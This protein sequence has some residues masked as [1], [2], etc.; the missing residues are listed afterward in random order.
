MSST[1]KPLTG[2]V[3]ALPAR[4]LSEETC[5]K[6]GYAVS[7]LA[8]GT[9]VQVASYYVKGTLV[10]QHTRDKNKDFKWLGESKGVELFGQ[11]LWREGGKMVVVT[12]G[13]IDAMSI[14]Q[15]NSHKYPV[16]SLPSGINGAVKALK[17]NLEWLETFES[18]ILMFDND[19]Q[20]TQAAEAVSK[21]VQECAALFTPGRCKIAKLP[22]KDANEML[23]ANR[24]GEVIEAIFGARE[25]RPDGVVSIADL[26][27]SLNKPVEMGLSWPWPTLTEYTYGI[28]LDEIYTL[29]AGTGMGK[30][31]F[32]KEVMVHLAN[33]H[34][35]KVGGL[36]LEETPAHTVRCLAGK[37]KDKRFH[38]PN[39]GWVQEDLDVAV[40]E[41]VEMDKIFL[42]DHFGHTDYEVIKARIRFMA[43]S[44]GC[45]YIFIDHITAL[46][47]G[48]L[49]GDE[50]KQLDYIMTD[51]A[52]LCRELHIAIF[53][54]SHLTSPEG[55]PHE[56]GGRVLL[57]QF[58]GSRAIG[59][60][61]SFCI[62][63]E[64]NQ[65]EQDEKRRNIT[66]V[67]VLKDRYT[68]EATGKLLYLRYEAETG[69]MKETEGPKEERPFS[70]KTQRVTEDAF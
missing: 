25:F 67:R 56:E 49:E 68:G 57:K 32:W 33:Q 65:Q 37:L 63:L 43:V 50:R 55:T 69:R 34:G 59:Q 44:L 27:S 58:R 46:V 45:T 40:D 54:I 47:S 8:N 5:R 48:D 3:K 29:G 4:K 17:A 6:F 9:A 38:V 21:A 28:R 18:V 60:W 52:S 13:E 64:R 2:E 31:E 22:L 14:S 26:K 23:V 70:D 36:F 30:S 41:L 61:S 12:E 11:H 51:L 7:S 1:F 20:G 15:I 16:V 19:P 62:G 53:C 66:T 24:A 10:A 42:F 35:Q 39:A